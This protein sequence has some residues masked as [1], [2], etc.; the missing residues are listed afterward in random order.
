MSESE[1]ISPKVSVILTS[2]NHAAYVAAAIESVLNQTFSDYELLIVDD[3]STDNSREIIRTFDD[4]RIKLF[5]YEKNRGPVTA[6]HD[7]INSARGKYIAVHHSDDLWSPD[8]LEKQVE[9]LD[10]NK[11]FA[12]CFT[13][14]GF[15]DE[16]GNAQK[17]DDREFYSKIFD[18]P[19]RSRAEWLNYFF[20]NANCLCHPSAV[21]RR[22]VV[23]E[24]HLY[25]AHGFWQ[26]PDYLAWIRLCFHEEIFILPERLTQFRLRKDKQENMSGAT[27]D[28]KIRGELEFFFV[29]REFLDTF[30]DDKFFTEVFTETKKFIVDGQINRRFA[31]ARLC[32]E[33]SSVANAAFQLAGLEILKDLLANPDDAAQ[34]KKLYG[35]DDKSFLR[36]GGSFDVFNL[37]QKFS[38]LHAEIFIGDEENLTRAAEKFISVDTS[39]KFYGRFDFEVTEPIKILRFDPDRNFTS[40]KINRVLINGV[41]REI[42][43][44][45]TSEFVNGFRRFWTT[46][47]QIF[48]NA[49]DLFGH[50]TFEIFGERE[51]NYQ[52][53]LNQKIRDFY[54]LRE[55]FRQLNEDYRQLNREYQRIKPIYEFFESHKIP[56]A[57]HAF[58]RWC[59][60]GN[61]DKAIAVARFFYKLISFGDKK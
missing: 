24:L 46:D 6:I 58:Y 20:Y 33:K 17:L 35:Y 9:F 47:P 7:A 18:Q 53:K 2:Y 32:L 5:L 27:F 38:M 37:A 26:L 29:L 19:N 39:Q 28:K 55:N 22:E 11:K 13:W 10:A 12:A 45:N 57:L 52:I 41:A 48:F 59:E 36:D 56:R 43:A 30:K 34:I 1:K 60:L 42:F 61:K 23:T 49:A 4:S 8:K 44:D 21:I 16:K 14:A 40:L 31:F 50:V 3:G 25:E 51:R 15:V 54:K